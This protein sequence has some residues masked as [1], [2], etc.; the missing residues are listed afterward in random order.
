MRAADSARHPGRLSR[1][2]RRFTTPSVDRMTIEPA[3]RERY[4]ADL[5]RALRIMAARPPVKAREALVKLLQRLSDLSRRV[6][7]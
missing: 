6:R 3:I 5:L 1:W 4:L 7:A 2:L